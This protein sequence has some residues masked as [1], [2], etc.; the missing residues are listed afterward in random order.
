MDVGV[1]EVE[2]SN[3]GVTFTGSDPPLNYT[4][5]DCPEGEVALSNDHY[6]QLCLLGEQ[7][8]RTE[9]GGG[10]CSPCSKGFYNEH[11]GYVRA[12]IA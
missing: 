5:D 12:R 4:V 1:Y 3:N 2:F 8:V 9:S 6:C 7:A 10:Y 11:S